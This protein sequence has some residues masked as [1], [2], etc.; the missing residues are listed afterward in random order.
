MKTI[1]KIILCSVLCLVVII[2]GIRLCLTSSFIDLEYNL[3]GV[4]EDKFGFTLEERTA[5]AYQSIDYLLGKVSDEEY[6][7]LTLPDGNPLFNERELSHMQDV[8]DLTLLVLRVW[9]GSLVLLLVGI[10]I[11]KQKGWQR[12]LMQAGKTAGIIIILFILTVLIAVTLNFDQLFTAFHHLFFEG[13]TWLFY[14]SDSLIR[15]FPTPFWVNVFLAVGIISFIL[16]LVLYFCCGKIIKETKR[17][18]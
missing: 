16:A 12:E 4:P 14:S 3:F 6:Q 15:L 2:G 11:G 1:F 17:E 10:F 9:Y 7:A 5:Y 18:V 13:D 8:R